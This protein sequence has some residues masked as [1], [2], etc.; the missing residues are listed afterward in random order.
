VSKIAFLAPTIEEATRTRK[1]RFELDN[2]EGRLLPG[3]FASAEMTLSLGRGLAVPESAVIRTGA[4][5]LVFVSHGP[6]GAHLE[7]REITLG[8]LVGDRYRVQAGLSAG[9]RVAHCGPFLALAV[10]TRSANSAAFF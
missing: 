9:E 4:R 3:A 5:S 7:P 8:P 1:V 2:K 10:C 6:E